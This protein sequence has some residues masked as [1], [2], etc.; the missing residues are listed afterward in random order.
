MINYVSAF[1]YKLISLRIISIIGLWMDIIQSFLKV[2]ITQSSR[3]RSRKVELDRVGFRDIFN[4]NLVIIIH[5]CITFEPRIT[6]L[7]SPDARFQLSVFD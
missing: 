1:Y 7:S 4:G 3:S 2:K 5:L 6:V